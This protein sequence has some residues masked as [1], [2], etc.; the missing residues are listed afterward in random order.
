MASEMPIIPNAR[1]VT[2]GG[3]D[4]LASSD[5][6]WQRG[7]PAQSKEFRINTPESG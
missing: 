2:I 3:K 7:W 4:D 5:S 1:L 6:G